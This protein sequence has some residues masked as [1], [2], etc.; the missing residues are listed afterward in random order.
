[1]SVTRSAAGRL[2]VTFLAIAILVALPF[3]LWGD[4]LEALFVGDGAVEQLSSHGSYAWAIAIL[5]LLSDLALPVPTSAVM[6]ALG[7]IYGPLLGGLIAALGSVLA[8]LTGYG[9]CRVFGRPLARFLSGEKALA[10]GERL[11]ARA[12]GWI[13]VLSRWLPVLSEVMACMAGLASMPFNLFLAALLCGSVPLGFAF[14]AIGHIGES[15]PV[16]TLGLSI[17]L[18]VILWLVCRPLLRAWAQK[19]VIVQKG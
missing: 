19:P 7:I 2:L 9:L 5:L 13:I 11:F 3:F 12:G 10:D 15:R 8:G 16:L 4:R 1:M 18:P 17:V 14:A 6:A